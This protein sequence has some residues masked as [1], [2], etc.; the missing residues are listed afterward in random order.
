MIRSQ[1]Y[2]ES[3]HQ[4][5]HEELA[6]K[7]A[8]YDFPDPYEK[9]AKVGEK[10]TYFC[11]KY[12]PKI[13]HNKKIFTIQA[14]LYS[15][16]QNVST[17]N[18]PLIG[19]LREELKRLK[20][21]YI[22]IVLPRE[23]NGEMINCIL[24][25]IRIQKLESI[26]ERLKINRRELLVGEQMMRKKLMILGDHVNKCVEFLNVQGKEGDFL[27]MSAEDIMRTVYTVKINNNYCH[28]CKGQIRF[29]KK[30]KSR[31]NDIVYIS[32]WNYKCIMG[33]SVRK[34]VA[35]LNKQY[36]SCSSYDPCKLCYE[37][38]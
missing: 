36:C 22:E 26:D 23:L 34:L 35:H 18:P 38:D 32:E 28:H 20:N 14:R 8:E 2:A 12:E 27:Q 30:Y 7:I 29:D 21:L 31:D 37:D 10:I 6:E 4:L 33:I 17:T 11:Q 5:S 13:H 19:K 9:L 16:L 24:D 25:I 3:L 1:T 15:Y